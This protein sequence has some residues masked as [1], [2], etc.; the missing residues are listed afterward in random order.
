MF[1]TKMKVISGHRV[2]LGYSI[3]AGK[4]KQKCCQNKT[5]SPVWNCIVKPGPFL[6]VLL[7]SCN[8]LLQ[9]HDQS[10]ELWTGFSEM[11]SQL[12]DQRKELWTGVSEMKSQLFDHRKE[13][14]TGVVELAS[15][16]LYQH[17]E[18]WAAPAEL[19]SQFFGQ[20]QNP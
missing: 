15:Q 7:I 14:W 10:Q 3:T 16:C 11:K 6:Y 18:V 17:H 9:I 19:T 2:S 12:F 13:L 5:D 20:G 1:H 4:A 8:N